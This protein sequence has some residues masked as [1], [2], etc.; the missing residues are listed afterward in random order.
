MSKGPSLHADGYRLIARSLG[1]SLAYIQQSGG[2]SAEPLAFRLAVDGLIRDMEDDNPR[3]DAR[4]F[5]RVMEAARL[6]EYDTEA[7]N[8]AEEDNDGE[9]KDHL[10]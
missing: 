5:R 1:R 2:Y 6:G 8:P 7:G 4:R 9:E 10:A 3:F